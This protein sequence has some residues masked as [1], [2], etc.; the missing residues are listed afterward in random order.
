MDASTHELLSPASGIEWYLK[1]TLRHVLPPDVEWGFVP[2]DKSELGDYGSPVA[3]ALAKIR[4]KSPQVLAGELA[5]HWESLPEVAKAQ[6]VNGYVNITLHTSVW[7]NMVEHIVS[8][9]S[10][11]GH[12]TWGQ[13]EIVNVEYVSANPTG[14]L[15]AA[16]ARGAVLGDVVANLLKA[17]GYDVVKE[18]YINDAGQQIARL[19]DTLVHHIKAM[20]SGQDGADVP[21]GLY[22]GEFA[23]HLAQEWWQ[24]HPQD[25][26]D[27]RHA[28]TR[29][30]VVSVMRD[31]QEVLCLLGVHHTVFT[32]EKAL[33]DTGAVDRMA[34]MLAHKGYSY[35]GTLPRPES[36]EQDKTGQDDPLLLFRST[37][38]GDEFDRALQRRE[39]G[40]TY[41][42]NDVAYH[43]DKLQRKA[44]HVIPVWGADH[45]SHVLRTTAAVQALTDHVMEVVL[46]QMVHFLKDGVPLKMSKRAGNVVSLRHVLSLIDADVLRFMLLTKKADTHLELDI[47]AMQEQSK[48]NPV[49]YVHYAHARCCSVLRA[50]QN[51]LPSSNDLPLDWSLWNDWDVVK[52]MAQWPH[53]VHQAALCREPHRI[54]AFLHKLAH[55]FH[56]LWH[57]GNQDH[58]LRLVQPNNLPYTRAAT[59]IVQAVAHVL[60]SGL[61]L[62][63]ITPK[64]EL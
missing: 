40:W 13:N 60:A 30:A 15:H 31:I 62:L 35:Y 16:H 14:P 59:C 28:L 18:Y 37:L 42:A 3:F 23:Q 29:F 48:D 27:D 45:A 12:Q 49:F 6:A 44:Q 63:G 34:S 5:S 2:C 26:N 54:P 50:T 52:I 32:S 11:Y 55:S 46:F 25:W 64:Q 4:K 10:A 7:V 53:V 9:K 58:H 24:N 61:E 47:T 51:L 21:E 22:P 19:T 38:W 39:G 56:A 41:F 1:N 36:T 17:V 57:K 33:Q 8:Q 43:M 20:E